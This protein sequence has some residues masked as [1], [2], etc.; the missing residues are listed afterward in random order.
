MLADVRAADA[1]MKLTWNPD[2]APMAPLDRY[3]G[4][5]VEVDRERN[6]YR[7]DGVNLSLPYM[8][9]G[10][11]VKGRHYYIQNARLFK[12][13]GDETTM[14]EIRAIEPVEISEVVERAYATFMADALKRDDALCKHCRT[15]R[16]KDHEDYL[17]H[18]MVYHPEQAI[19][20]I[21]APEPAPAVEFQT[22]TAS[23]DPL[24]CCG[25]KFKDVRGVGA[26]QRFGK[27]HR[28]A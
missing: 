10:T 18:V 1:R 3:V 12:P 7:I 4:K 5:L 27:E 11:Y 21:Q 14:E 28:R 16:S 17:S 22:P 8:M 26:H 23:V 2:R 25:K 20:F 24:V 6:I 15:Y 9:I 13:N 19:K